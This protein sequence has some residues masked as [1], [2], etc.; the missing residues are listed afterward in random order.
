MKGNDVSEAQGKSKVGSTQGPARHPTDPF[1]RRDA[2]R[3]NEVKRLSALQKLRDLVP[4]DQ[5]RLNGIC[6]VAALITQSEAAGLAF[7][8]DRFLYFSGRFGHLPERDVRGFSVEDVYNKLVF[9][10]DA[11]LM[12]G[13]ARMNCLNGKFAAY[14]S[15]I[16]I[17]VHY[18]GHPV[19]MLCCFAKDPRDG[20][21]PDVKACLYELAYLAEAYLA[22]EASLSYLARTAASAMERLRGTD[23]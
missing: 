21:S 17:A 19:A 11:R 7:L 23:G 16:G 10:P 18:E 22:Q 14:G 9:I 13:H 3:A 15:M 6:R 20:H 2:D 12:P 4:Q 1:A 5:P 8:S